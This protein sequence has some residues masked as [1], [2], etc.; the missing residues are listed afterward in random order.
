MSYPVPSPI[1][2]S[3][4]DKYILKKK[5]TK[6]SIHKH[7]HSHLGF[8]EKVTL[9]YLKVSMVCNKVA[10]LLGSG[11]VL[12]TMLGRTEETVMNNS[13]CA[14]VQMRNSSWEMPS[15]IPL[16]YRLYTG[17]HTDPVS[18]ASSSFSLFFLFRLIIKANHISKRVQRINLKCTVGKNFICAYTHVT[19]IQINV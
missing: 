15:P 7:S 17:V 12:C 16:A 18:S 13:L 2:I 9:L 4:C 5:T 3:F 10:F 6:C 14:V 1:I 11:T 19:T 8:L